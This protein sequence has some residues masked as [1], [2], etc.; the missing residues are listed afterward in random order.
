[1][2]FLVFLCAFYLVIYSL[3]RPGECRVRSSRCRIWEFTKTNSDH[4]VI[5]KTREIRADGVMRDTQKDGADIMDCVFAVRA[6][7]QRNKSSKNVQKKRKGPRVIVKVRAINH[8]LTGQRTSPAV[9]C[10]YY[11]SARSFF[12]MIVCSRSNEYFRRAL[13]LVLFWVF[14]YSLQVLSEVLLCMLL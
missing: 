14:Y 5:A 9:Y 13:P 8:Q 10:F 4:S 3:Q 2:Y 11:F 1:M 12:C 7:L 6:E